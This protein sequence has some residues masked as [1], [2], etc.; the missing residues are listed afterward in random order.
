MA[1]LKDG[2]D[3]FGIVDVVVAVEH[4]MRDLADFAANRNS[5][6]PRNDDR[7]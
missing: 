3:E 7:T 2:K 6:R 4:D 5:D 1:P